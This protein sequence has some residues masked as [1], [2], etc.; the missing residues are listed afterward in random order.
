MNE[1]QRQA[2]LQ[3][4]GVT[5]WVA[6]QPLPGAKASELLE[7]PEHSAPVESEAAPA[8]GQPA[9]TQQSSAPAEQAPP[10]AD[11]SAMLKSSPSAPA[12]ADAPRTESP[13][14]QTTAE[15]ASPAVAPLTLQLASVGD[16]VLAV[17]Q[18]DPGAP[19]LGREAQ[20]LFAN[21][22]KVF[23][24]Q[25]RRLNRFTWPML[26]QPDD[27]LAMTFQHFAAHLRG[28]SKVLLCVSDDNAARLAAGPRYQRQ[29][30][31]EQTVLAVS[32]LEEMLAEP[33][34]HKARSW[35]A[36]LTQGFAQQGE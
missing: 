34:A 19:E 5:P 12:Q 8:Q 26:D 14:A 24:G 25:S 2:Y 17:E 1:L 13:A 6:Q 11:L 23:R 9:P 18:S 33:Q 7:W 3:A 32:S 20:Q 28:A 16:V 31:G 27:A 36:M 22:L 30:W 4:L 29:Q 21:L 10:P 35:Q 15:A